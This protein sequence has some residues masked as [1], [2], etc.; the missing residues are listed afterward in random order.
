MMKLYT[1][2]PEEKSQTKLTTMYLNK[3][4]AVVKLNRGIQVFSN[5]SK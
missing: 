4:F 5:Q 3:G 2:I 1:G